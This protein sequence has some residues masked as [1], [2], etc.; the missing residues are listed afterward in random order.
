MKTRILGL[1]GS[2]HPQSASR[3]ALMYAL[4]VCARNGAQVEFL[5]LRTFLLPYCNGEYDVEAYPEEYEDN[6]LYFRKMVKESHGLVLA[7]P[8]YHGGMSGVLKNA[9]DHLDLPETQGKIVALI[10]AAG[11]RGGLTT[12]GQMRLICRSLL[13]WTVPIQVVLSRAEVPVEGHGPPQ[14]PDIERR[15][16]LMADE[17]VKTSRLHQIGS[18]LGNRIFALG[19]SEAGSEEKERVRH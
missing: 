11:R 6:I 12:L 7:S 1:C 4:E 13:T 15:L 9:I 3:S 5:D 17:L 18:H 2:L 14:N 10:A 19:R 16:R 8:E